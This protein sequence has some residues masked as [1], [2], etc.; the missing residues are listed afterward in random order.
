MWLGVPQSRERVIFMGVRK[1][2]GMKP[3]YPKPFEYY[4]TLSDAFDNLANDEAQAKELTATIAKYSIGKVLR[5]I[6]K[7]PKK[8]ISGSD[9]MGG[10]YFN[11]VRESMEQPCTTICQMGGGASV[12]TICHPS[13]DRKFTIPELKRITSVPDDFILTGDY[14][15][16]WERLGRMVPPLMMKAIA[17]NAYE[18][19]LCKTK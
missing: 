12:A 1:D 7:N 9:V 2:L 6:P 10:S 8:P 4:Y 16:Q 14:A 15:Q 17:K 5:R 19:I 11:L 13:E 3:V 18:V